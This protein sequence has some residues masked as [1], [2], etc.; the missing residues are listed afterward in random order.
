MPYRDQN[1][2][3]DPQLPREHLFRAQYPAIRLL[4]AGA[5]RGGGPLF[6]PAAHRRCGAGGLDVHPGRRAVC[7]LRLFQLPRHDG[8]AT[9]VG[10]DQV[11]NSYAQTVGVP[12]GLPV[13]TCGICLPKLSMRSTR[14]LPSWP[15]CWAT[16]ASRPPA[17]TSWRPARR[18]RG[19]WNGCTCCYK[20][21]PT[22]KSAFCCSAFGGRFRASDK[23]SHR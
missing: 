13:L 18:T 22:T 15:T 7:R 17:S 21:A 12:V 1:P 16:P 3:R 14:T 19:C 10:V 20:K 4:T 11:R 2:Q 5:W 9:A 6:L 23:N 8:R